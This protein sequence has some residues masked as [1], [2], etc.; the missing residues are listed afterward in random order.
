MVDLTALAAEL[1]GHTPLDASERA[2]WH[3][4]RRLIESAVDASSRTAFDPGHLTASA[5]LRDQSGEHILLIRHAKLGKWLQP[6]GHVE[7]TDVSLERAAYRELQE[8]VGPVVT[9]TGTLLDVDVHRIPPH[10]AEPAHFHFDVR[11]LFDLADG[12]PAAGDGALALR[13]VGLADLAGGQ[14][15]DDSVARLL[16]RA[17]R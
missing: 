12:R 6:G 4:L 14:I 7:V 3:A 9:G 2:S 13:W 15:E 10:R 5:V 16:R 8:E 11:Y 1:A 17:L